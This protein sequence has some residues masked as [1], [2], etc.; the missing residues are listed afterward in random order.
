MTVADLLS[1]FQL[2][3][4]DISDVSQAVF[5]QWSNMVNRY[6]Y[7]LIRGIDSQRYI[8]ATTFNIVSTGS[9][10]TM[11]LP[12]DFESMAEWDTG[13]YLTDGNGNITNT[14]LV[15]TSPSSQINGY[16][17]NAGNVTFTGDGTQTIILKYIPNV[18]ALTALVDVL[19]IPDEYMEYA[20]KAIDVLYTQW[21][22]DVGAEGISD[23]RY[24][25]VL[26]EM[27]ANIRRVPTAYNMPDFSGTF[28]TS[29][30]IP[31]L[32]IF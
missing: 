9:P 5:L 29:T 2:F 6:A 18:A 7:R 26:D 16:F 12:L 31:G 28:S 22:E 32:L 3:K 21:D 13:F 30:G 25:R 1:N 10:V 27:A 24:T 15:L 11:P 23:Q 14:R 17:L 4:K 20:V 19:V 8:L